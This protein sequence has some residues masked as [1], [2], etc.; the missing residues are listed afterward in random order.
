MS[1]S[2][3]FVVRSLLYCF[4]IRALVNEVHNFFRV[5]MM[6]PIVEKDPLL[7]LESSFPFPYR[8]TVLTLSQSMARV[9]SSLVP[10]SLEEANA[11]IV[12]EASDFALHLGWYPRFAY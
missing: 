11:F 3:V 7:L 5:D 9:T 10:T 1:M 2:V 8:V 12:D 6:S 4:H